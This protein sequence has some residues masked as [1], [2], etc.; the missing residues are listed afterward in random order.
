MGMTLDKDP[1]AGKPWYRHPWVWFVIAL[2]AT[3]IVASLSLVAISVINRDDLVR[4]DW[5][6]AGRAI[7]QDIRADQQARE[8]G[9]HARLVLEPASLAVLIED[10]P[11]NITVPELRLALHHNT[12]AREDMDVS[13]TRRDDGRYQGVLPRLPL[14]K[15]SLVLEPLALVDGQDHWRLRA[16]DVIFQGE[17]VALR[18]GY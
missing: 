1:M 16:G 11:A 3:S 4:D 17:P 2:P 15:R 13:L 12:L 8:L 14:G 9:L 6:K 5:Y 18:P 7:N 10:L